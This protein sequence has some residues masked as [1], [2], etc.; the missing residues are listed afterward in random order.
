MTDID[1]DELDRAV[2]SAVGG[3]QPVAD[4]APVVAP[5]SSS[6]PISVSVNTPK[7]QNSIP[8]R[9]SSSG[10]FMDVVPPS[11]STR[12]NISTP[13]VV[14]REAVTVAPTTE[15]IEEVK[16]PVEPA[17][18][19]G[20]PEDPI[21]NQ[22]PDPIDFQGPKKADEESIP[23]ENADSEDADIDRISDDINKTLEVSNE[24]LD[25][26]F[27]ADAKVEKRP[28][29]AFSNNTESPIVAPEGIEA[30]VE[31]NLSSDNTVD[32]ELPELPELPDE[33]ALPETEQPEE[34]SVTIEEPSVQTEVVSQPPV[35]TTPTPVPSVAAPATTTATPMEQPT[36]PTSIT[37][38]YREQPSTAASQTSGAIYDTDAYHKA[39]KPVK[40]KSS[41]WMVLWIF[42]LLAIGA[43][44]GA[45]AYF[46]ILPNL[47]L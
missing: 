46:F 11:V 24:P 41:W 10:K 19:A 36:G 3:G 23:A 25:T 1:F 35:E 32:T 33:A 38:Q 17:P 42:L 18:G 37:Q 31:D 15:V 30:K 13:E 34:S 45:A 40:S 16:P 39:L 5:A 9:R 26:P 12:V 27:L 22:W 8:E 6:T 21:E 2:N 14:S 7:P 20:V 44:A 4:A 47:G 43:G 28:L 29:G